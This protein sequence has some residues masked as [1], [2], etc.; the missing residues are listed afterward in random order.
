M[1]SRFASGFAGFL[2]GTV[3]GLAVA[4]GAALMLSEG[5][6]PLLDKVGVVTADV[7]PAAKL[8]G[9]INP[10]DVLNQRESLE[11]DAA[12]QGVKT[13]DVS[14]K[15][16]VPVFWVQTGAFSQKDRAVSVCGRIAMNG[17]PCEAIE[18]NKLWKP[19][20]GSFT[21]RIDAVNTAER[22]KDEL[23]LAGKVVQKP[24]HWPSH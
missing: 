17:M 11:T 18:E 15:T 22:L 1:A 19:M 23:D 16:A 13:V 14:A 21:D 20:V 24:A 5:V 8:N 10:N 4:A 2:I 9:D 6:S 7:D 12:P 3:F